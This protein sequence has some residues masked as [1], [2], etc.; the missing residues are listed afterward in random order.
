MVIGEEEYGEDYY[1]DLKE[2]DEAQIRILEA[3]LL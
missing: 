1:L 3:E 2:L